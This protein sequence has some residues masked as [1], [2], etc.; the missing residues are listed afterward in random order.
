MGHSITT[1]QW[2][3]HSYSFADREDKIKA[4]NTIDSGGLAYDLTLVTVA[5]DLADRRNASRDIDDPAELN[6]QSS[7]LDKLDSKQRSM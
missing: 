6:F 4:L 7:D 3:D 2:K 5:N 1:T